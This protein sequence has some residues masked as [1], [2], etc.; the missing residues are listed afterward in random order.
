MSGFSPR[1]LHFA[2]GCN[3]AKVQQIRYIW[4]R[5]VHCGPTDKIFLT[6][7]GHKWIIFL[8]N[9][10][11]INY[12]RGSMVRQ[13]NSD[14]FA[15]W[16]FKIGQMVPKLKY[17]KYFVASLCCRGQVRRKKFSLVQYEFQ[18]THRTVTCK[19]ILCWKFL[20]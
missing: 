5:P 14:L 10:E 1:N 16:I 3:S 19:K 9:A 18:K 8:R 11:Q 6:D 7:F 4:D 17:F 12:A 20:N 2:I 13:L 15:F